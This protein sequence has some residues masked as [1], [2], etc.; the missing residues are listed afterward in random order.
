MVLII[1]GT[2][3]P[4]CL[5]PFYKVSYYTKWA[6]TSWTYSTS[7]IDAQVCSEIDNLICFIH[8]SLQ[9]QLT[10]QCTLCPRSLDPLLKAIYGI[11]GL[12]LRKHKV[13]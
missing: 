9:N 6:K 4:R 1:N 13:Q 7:D 5:D 11:N 3:C 12:K 8:F 10:L 2:M